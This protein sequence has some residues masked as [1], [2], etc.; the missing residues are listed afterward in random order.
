MLS[1]FS[2]SKHERYEQAPVYIY[3]CVCV[4]VKAIAT[5][6][7]VPV[8]WSN[9]SSTLFFFMSYKSKLG[10]DEIPRHI[11]TQIRSVQSVKCTIVKPMKDFV[12]YAKESRL[13]ES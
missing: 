7:E 4:H 1:I 11:P 3:M 10:S 9:G 2:K 13:P 5:S 6:T 12:V 8:S